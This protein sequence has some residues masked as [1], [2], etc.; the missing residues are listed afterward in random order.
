MMHVCGASLTDTRNCWFS[1]PWLFLRADVV[2][3]NPAESGFSSF[4]GYVFLC[5]SLIC[6]NF[7]VA[8]TALLPPPSYSFE[9]DASNST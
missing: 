6:M 5:R 1:V 2:V 7:D 9:T 4:R 3:V 8:V